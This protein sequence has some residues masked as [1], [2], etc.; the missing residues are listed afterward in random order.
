MTSKAFYFTADFLKFSALVSAECLKPLEKDW[1]S[2]SSK[3]HGIK[4][5]MAINEARTILGKHEDKL[6]SEKS[7]VK[8]EERAMVDL[9]TNAYI[10]I[11]PITGEQTIQKRRGRSPK[12]R[13]AGVPTILY[14]SK[15]KELYP[16]DKLVKLR[17][18]LQKILLRPVIKETELPIAKDIIKL[19]FKRRIATME[20]IK[21]YII[22]VM[23]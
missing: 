19:L 16:H 3:T 2:L 14:K 5:K 20:Q 10:V 8:V 22:N 15:G 9:P 11:D 7:D 6:E 18:K 12:K 17:R 1:E 21:V 13:P 4:F 23:M